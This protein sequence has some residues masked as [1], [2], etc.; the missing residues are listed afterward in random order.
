MN[1]VNYITSIE[2]CET[3]KLREAVTEWMKDLSINNGWACSWV[4][5]DKEKDEYAEEDCI[6]NDYFISNGI[7]IGEVVIVHVKW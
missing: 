4:V 1:K 6:I 3:A 7:K 2:L 5:F